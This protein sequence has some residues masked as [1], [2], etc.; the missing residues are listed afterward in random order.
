MICN[1]QAHTTAAGAALEPRHQSTAAAPCVTSHPAV[2]TFHRR[3]TGVAA[4][5]RA[6]REAVAAMAARLGLD[7]RSCAYLWHYTDAY[8]KTGYSGAAALQHAHREGTRLAAHGHLP[9]PNQSAPSA[10][11][12]R[13]ML[14]RDTQTDAQN[15]VSFI[16][17]VV[18]TTCA[19]MPF[20]H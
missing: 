4:R 7:P 16:A 9:E 2:L 19:L 20:F 3:C 8:L 10:A 17:G 18:L 6:T 14:H 1:D 15:V 12:V 5:R 13:Q 11:Q